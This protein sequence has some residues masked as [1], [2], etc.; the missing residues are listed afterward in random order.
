M[1]GRHAVSRP[2]RPAPAAGTARHLRH[3]LTLLLLLLVAACGELPRPF[4]PE[5]KTG[6][7]LLA[8][9]EGVS[10]EVLPLQGHAPNLPLGGAAYVAEGLAANGLA[11]TLGGRTAQS[12]LLLGVVAVTPASS[13]SD[14]V[15]IS[16]EVYGPGGSLL[17]RYAQQTEVP[18]NRWL[19]GDP[20]TLRLV[21]LDAGPVL[22]PIAA[23][24]ELVPETGATVAADADGGRVRI[25]L[26][27]VS[28]APGDGGRSLPRALSSVLTQRGFLVV[29]QPLA[30]D[31]VVEGIIT[32]AGAGEGREQITLAWRLL[33]G[34]KGSRLGEVQ[35]GNVIPAG[36]LDGKWG[37]VAA[38][39][40][41]GA[42]DGILDL[43]KQAGKL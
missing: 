12:R 39:I 24:P 6:N 20:D 27:G 5:D 26:A 32:V 37:D 22:G 1:P 28:G 19:A 13:L 15:I 35:Q 42:A 41:V 43:L 14:Y 34:P 7:P 31:L 23:G 4:Q 16:W 36:S 10:L 9:I 30:G 38:L 29:E 11:V 21:G 40:A 18:K 3:A 17:G 33:D 2:I 8:P 25:A